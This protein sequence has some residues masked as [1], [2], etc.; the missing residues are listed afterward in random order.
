M[1]RSVWPGQRPKANAAKSLEKPCSSRLLQGGSGDR[2]VGPGADAVPES[3]PHSR[4]GLFSWMPWPD[5]FGA[6]RVFPSCCQTC[7]LA[8][9][10]TSLWC[11]PRQMLCWGKP[12]FLCIC[13]VWKRWGAGFSRSHPLKPTQHAKQVSASAVCT[14][15]RAALD[16]ASRQQNIQVYMRNRADRKEYTCCCLRS[17]KGLYGDAKFF[18]QSF[19]CKAEVHKFVVVQWRVEFC[20]SS[21]VT[22]SCCREAMRCNVGT[23]RWLHWWRG[24]NFSASSTW[25]WTF[26]FTNWG[27]TRQTK[28]NLSSPPE[29]AVTGCDILRCSFWSVGWIKIAPQSGKFSNPGAPFTLVLAPIW[30][31]EPKCSTNSGTKTISRKVLFI[32]IWRDR[33]HPTCRGKEEYP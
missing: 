23:A 4:I 10:C 30:P 33:M 27:K 15:F 24:R 32:S 7:L 18:L 17:V 5:H 31:F 19:Y 13:Q 21:V 6:V 26:H 20:V 14:H 3:A 16:T 2:E 25:P 9:T 1:P 11:L 29:S 12:A 22:V 8:T 28:S